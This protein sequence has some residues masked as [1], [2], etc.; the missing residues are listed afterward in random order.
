[1]PQRK[2][3]SVHIRV[4]CLQ[5]RE[6]I[7]SLFPNRDCF[8]LVRPHND[9]KQLAQLESLPSNQLRKEFIEVSC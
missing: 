3:S 5:I 1:M 8:C 2:V 9:E 6:S 7:K 4:G